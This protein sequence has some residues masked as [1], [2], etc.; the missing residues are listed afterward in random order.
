MLGQYIKTGHYHFLSKS[1]PIQW[2]PVALSLEVKQLGSEDD[3]LPQS[4]TEV[5][6]AWSYTSTPQIRLH[7]VVL[8]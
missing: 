5:K 1:T 8:S 3:Q 6:N 7:G 4:S 2:M